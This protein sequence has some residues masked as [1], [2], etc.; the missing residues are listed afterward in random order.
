MKHQNNLFKIIVGGSIA[1][2][3]IAASSIFIWRSRKTSEEKV[4]ITVLSHNVDEIKTNPLENTSQLEALSQSEDPILKQSAR[5][6]LQVDR[7]I[8]SNL[9]I[10]KVKNVFHK[11]NIRK[12]VEAVCEVIGFEKDS[13]EVVKNF[14]QKN[15][16]FPLSDHFRNNSNNI[17]RIDK[18]LRASGK[19]LP[20]P[21]FYHNG[22]LES[23]KGFI[24]KVKDGINESVEG[25][26]T[27]PW[28]NDLKGCLPA[29][30]TNMELSPEELIDTVITYY[31]FHHYIFSQI[32]QEDAME[33][34]VY[35]AE[36]HQ[37]ANACKD[38]K[39]AQYYADKQAT[40]ISLQ[41]AN[42]H[43]AKH[44]YKDY[45]YV[46]AEQDKIDIASLKYDCS[47]IN[48][49]KKD[50]IEK[51][52]YTITK[53]YLNREQAGK[54]RGLAVDDKNFNQLFTNE[55]NIN[56]LENKKHIIIHIN[57]HADHQGNNT[58]TFLQAAFGLIDEIKQNTKKPVYI[59]LCL[60]GGFTIKS[61]RNKL[62][63]DSIR[64][65]IKKA[66]CTIIQ[67]QGNDIHTTKKECS[68]MQVHM[69]K[70]GKREKELSDIIIVSNNI[71]V[72]DT[73]LTPY[74]E[75]S[76]HRAIEAKVVL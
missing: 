52:H 65:I 47:A 9:K 43:L 72:V 23:V 45:G 16:D 24:I 67:H 59:I 74:T 50:F 32:Y 53:H 61:T 51:N 28:I 25:Y 35:I 2:A 6:L 49:Y 3:I 39:L 66:N 36:N 62:S 63:L 48:F 1:L 56:Q 12:I 60:D 38:E 15:G 58:K 64:S 41:D 5:K 33:D 14:L 46:I 18:E 10:H 21:I 42:S 13:G 30:Y 26:F 55:V 37:K 29:L 69:H 75:L 4:M 68:H 76:G 7:H 71:T 34:L 22:F 11:K 27:T 70:A 19:D 73:F 31:L 17:Q 44:L 57:F 8:A 40:F 54:Y 20:S